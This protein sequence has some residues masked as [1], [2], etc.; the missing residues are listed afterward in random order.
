MTASLG[1]FT[2]GPFQGSEHRWL[3]FWPICEYSKKYQTLLK[4]TKQTSSWDTLIWS[5]NASIQIGYSSGLLLLTDLSKL[6]I[7][8]IHLS[9]SFLFQSL[10]NSVRERR[11][12]ENVLFMFYIIIKILYVINNN[13]CSI[14]YGVNTC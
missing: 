2:L 9:R 5:T 14:M 8:K 11:S 13:V 10:P 4:R 7:P 12:C 1:V 3:D 6:I